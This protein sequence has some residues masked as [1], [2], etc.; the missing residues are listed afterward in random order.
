MTEYAAPFDY[1]K[2]LKK[3]NAK[4]KDI[5]D[6]KDRKSFIERE[7]VE[8]DAYNAMLRRMSKFVNAKDKNGKHPAGLR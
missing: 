5:S 4:A 7:T 8:L 3:I 6:K 1:K 2:E